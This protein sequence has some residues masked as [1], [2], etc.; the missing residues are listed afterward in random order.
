M[1]DGLTGKIAKLRYCIPTPNEY[2]GWPSRCGSKSLMTFLFLSDGLNPPIRIVIVYPNI[3]YT[4][5]VFPFLL[6]FISIN[7]PFPNQLSQYIPI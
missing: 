4:S 7:H 1:N 5:I 6:G 2:I 3:F